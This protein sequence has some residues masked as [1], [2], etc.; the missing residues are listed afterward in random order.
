MR[1]RRPLLLAVVAL[2]CGCEDQPWPAGPP[3]TPEQRAAAQLWAERCVPCHGQAGTGDGERAQTL[4][5]RPRDLTERAWQDTEHD[6]ELR[7]VILLGGEPAGYSAEMPASPDL[8][9]RPV[10]L[11]QLIVKLRSL[12]R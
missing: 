1:R 12:R 10:V 2:G 4:R 5:T 8:K 9:E 3:R 7:F 6:D 11:D